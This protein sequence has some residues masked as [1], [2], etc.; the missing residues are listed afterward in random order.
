[1]TLHWFS[2]NYVLVHHLY[3]LCLY[4]MKGRT[5]PIHQWRTLRS[6]VI[7]SQRFQREWWWVT[8]CPWEGPYCT[9]E[10][11][12]W[13]TEMPNMREV[14]WDTLEDPSRSTV[15]WTIYAHKVSNQWEC[16]KGLGAC[17][18]LKYQEHMAFLSA[19][20]MNFHFLIVRPCHWCWTQPV[21]S[22]SSFVAATPLL[23]SIGALYLSYF[24]V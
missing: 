22:V 8:N 21:R 1:M 14:A 5:L 4:F 2:T 23:I 7:N 20:G 11:H 24:H 12:P 6:M 10:T 16:F 13:R 15:L 3:K 9:K 18:K 19:R 17:D